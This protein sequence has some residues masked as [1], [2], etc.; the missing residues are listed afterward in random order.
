MISGP[1]EQNIFGK[2]GVYECLHIQKKSMSLKE[3]KLKMGV[4]D[5]ITDGL[6]ANEV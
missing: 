6:S 1:I 5:K 2:G 3:Y 4:F